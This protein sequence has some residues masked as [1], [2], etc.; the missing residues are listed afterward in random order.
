MKQ[1]HES[2]VELK[3]EE[4][5]SIIDGKHV[6]ELLTYAQINQGE[7]KLAHRQVIELPEE[8]PTYITEN[9]LWDHTDTELI[10]LRKLM[11]FEQATELTPEIKERWLKSI[12]DV[13]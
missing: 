4:R 6:L 12:E 3:T 11:D 2:E 9:E 5:Y 7:R 10:E 8:I 13:H 1:A